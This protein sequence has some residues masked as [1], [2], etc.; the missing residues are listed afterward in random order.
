[1]VGGGRDTT[2]VGKNWGGR[3]TPGCPFDLGGGRRLSACWTGPEGVG[4]GETRKAFTK[5][6]VRIVEGLSRGRLRCT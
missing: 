4:G 3:S 1:V 2:H 6:G 5:L